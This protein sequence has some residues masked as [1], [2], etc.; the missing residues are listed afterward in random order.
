M[1]SQPHLS[2]F[3]EMR[4]KSNEGGRTPQKF[5]AVV[6]GKSEKKISNVL[7]CTAPKTAENS[8]VSSNIH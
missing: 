3:F 4:K 6:E 5:T 8:S 2:L 7:W 1:N